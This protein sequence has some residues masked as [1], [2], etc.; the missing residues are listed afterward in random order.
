MAATPAI[1]AAER[2][3][4]AFELH[5]YTHD[6]RSSDYGGEAVAAMAEL[7]GAD[8]ERIFKTL[9]VET[10]DG[11]PAVAV[12]PVPQQLSLKAMA[13]ALGVARVVMAPAA[14]VTRITGYVLGGVSPLGQKRPLPTVVDETAQLWDTVLVSAG[15]RGL[16][17]ELAPG[18]L[19]A[20]TAGRYADIA[21]G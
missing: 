21:A 19:V 16:E 8:P 9:V 11:A 5:R 6:P 20:L 13:S 15:R 3:G 7:I 1:A 17:I 4:I 18:D 14:A 10:G 12:V 2:A